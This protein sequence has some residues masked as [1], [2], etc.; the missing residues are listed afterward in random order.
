MNN[1]V[2]KN[3]TL[4][5]MY[6]IFHFPSSLFPFAMMHP[7]YAKL[8]QSTKNVHEDQHTF[9]Q[10][11]VSW[12]GHQPE[13][14]KSHHPKH[15]FLII[16]PQFDFSG[17]WPSIWITNYFVVHIPVVGREVIHRQCTIS[18]QTGKTNHLIMQ[19]MIW[20]FWLS[21]TKRPETPPRS[22]HGICT[23]G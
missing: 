10:Y 5:Q 17:W 7:I 8:V 14:T 12:H 6:L 13:K 15:N 21:S 1:D 2:V 18:L 23:E 19:E 22:H 3:A 11:S 20:F 4:I 9:L 16:S